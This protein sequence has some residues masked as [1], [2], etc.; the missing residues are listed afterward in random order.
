MK[1][2]FQKKN[3]NNFPSKEISKNKLKWVGLTGSTVKYM[4]VSATTSYIL[5]LQPSSIDREKVDQIQQLRPVHPKKL[6]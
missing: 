2:S 3:V 1:M 4:C 6:A 5:Y